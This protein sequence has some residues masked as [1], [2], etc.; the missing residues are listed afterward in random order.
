MLAYAAGDAAAFDQLYSRHRHALYQF[1]YNSCNSEA[2]ARELYQDVW[3]RVVKNRDRYQHGTPFNAWL[4]RIARHRVIDHYRAQS[5]KPAMAQATDLDDT[6][7]NVSSLFAMPLMPDEI[8]SLTQRSD[9]LGSALQ[10][11]PDVQREAVLLRHIAGMSI[12]E[13]ASVV[14]VGVETVKSRLR[15]AV[16]KLR[17]TLQEYS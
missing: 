17:S 12:S 1:A 16:V 11:L 9:I 8:A 13:V 7:T 15:Y 14:N 5:R 10:S 6:Y 4:Y 3:L 2:T